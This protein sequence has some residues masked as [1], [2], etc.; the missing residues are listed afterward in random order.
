MATSAQA[1]AITFIHWLID[2]CKNLHIVRER[3]LR[4]LMSM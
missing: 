2:G 3:D 1:P 4:L